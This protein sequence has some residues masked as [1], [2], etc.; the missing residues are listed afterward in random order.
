MLT[1]MKYDVMI[2]YLGKAKCCVELCRPHQK[3]LSTRSFE[4]LGTRT[5]VITTNQ[6]IK[7]YDFYNPQN[8][9]VVDE[10]NP[11]IPAD[12]INEPYT[13]I[14]DEILNRYTLQYFV[15]TLLL[16]Q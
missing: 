16:I 7:N 11:I 13:N 15:R 14:K 1:P 3:S 10:N 9:L 6:S 8:I 2:N 12:W 5:K 4:A